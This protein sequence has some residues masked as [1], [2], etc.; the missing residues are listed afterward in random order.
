MSESSP[1]EGSMSRRHSLSMAM[2]NLR[3]T[4]GKQRPGVSRRDSVTSKMSGL[5]RSM[6]L[7]LRRASR[8]SSLD[9]DLQ[10]DKRLVE[11]A[12]VKHWNDTNIQVGSLV[13]N[14]D[15]TNIRVGSLVWN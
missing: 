3:L 5:T 15:D 2:Q 10:I 13:W 14:W 8:S 4:T 6:S 7:G 11:S 9:C 12:L 1:A